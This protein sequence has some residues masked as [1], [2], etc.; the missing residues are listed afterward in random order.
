[1]VNASRGAPVTVAT[2][3][4]VTLTVITS[5]TSYPSALAGVLTMSTDSTAMGVVTEPFTL[6]DESLV[7]AC[8]P[9][10]RVAGTP[11]VESW[12]VA[13]FSVRALAPTPMP[14]PSLSDGWTVYS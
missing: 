13:P 6:C 14:S 4:K 2:L 7:I 8:V 3:E 9:R 12:I 5:S 11:L 1:M 10:S